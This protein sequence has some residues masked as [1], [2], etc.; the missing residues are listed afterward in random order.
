MKDERNTKTQIQVYRGL[1]GKDR[2]K[3]AKKQRYIQRN[4]Q[5]NMQRHSNQ[6]RYKRKTE[7]GQRNVWNYRQNKRNGPT[8]CKQKK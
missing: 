4:I 8:Q 1:L 2:R 5:R 3:S 6:S 7:N